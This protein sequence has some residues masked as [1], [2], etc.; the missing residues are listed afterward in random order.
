MAHA[1]YLVQLKKDVFWLHLNLGVK[2]SC[3]VTSDIQKHI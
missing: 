1:K 2:F 3:H